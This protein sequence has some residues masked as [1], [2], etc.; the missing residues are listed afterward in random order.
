[1]KNCI[2][3]TEGT[4]KKVPWKTVS[5]KMVPEKWSPEKNGTLEKRSSKQNPRKKGPRKNGL[6][7]KGFR[8]NGPR[9][10][11]SRKNVLKKLFFVERM[12][13]NS[14]DFFIIIDRLYY[15]HIK[16]F[17]VNLAILYAPNCRTL[18]ESS[19][20]CCR[21]LGL[22]PSFGFVVEFWVFID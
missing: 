15:T 3:R 12:L 16:M 4:R 20:V 8:R 10:N 14:N 17:D 13:G 21:A 7:T 19:K 6:R 2:G 18:N 5:E 11:H 1:M 9:R 22:F